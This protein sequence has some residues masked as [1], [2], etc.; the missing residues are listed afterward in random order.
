MIEIMRFR[1]ASGVR[2]SDFLQGD[3]EVQESFA[4][5]QPGLL[6]RTTARGAEG[7]WVVIDL[8]RSIADCDACALRWEEDPVPRRF[9]T[10]VDHGSVSTE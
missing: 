1:L 8:W 7:T 2:E 6:R 5:R 9:M 4:Y 3:R 10:L